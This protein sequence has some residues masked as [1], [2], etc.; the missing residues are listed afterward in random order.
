MLSYLI[1]CTIII[2]ILY[3]VTL[4][5]ITF[6]YLPLSLSL[7]RYLSDFC[8]WYILFHYIMLY[9]RIYI[10]IHIIVFILHWTKY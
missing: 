4:D 2:L 5:S 7:H 9:I 1:V 6:V 10:Y 8:L 3:H